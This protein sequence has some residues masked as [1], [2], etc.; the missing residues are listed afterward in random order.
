[1]VAI[2]RPGFLTARE[3]RVR[4][5]V[6][7]AGLLAG[8]DAA[9]SELLRRRATVPRRRLEPGP[10][11]APAHAGA[12]ASLGLLVLDGLMIRSLDLDGRRCPELIGPG[13]LLRPWDDDGPGAVCC[14]ATW[15]VLEPTAL[16]VL[17][18]RFAAAICRWPAIVSELLSRA[19]ERSRALAFHLAIAHIRHAQTRLRMLLWHLADRW[20]R[21]TD[22]GV[23]VPLALT[24]ELLAHLAC[25]RR[26]SAS[27]ALQLLARGGELERRRD[28][29]W[30]LT[31]S[32]P[33]SPA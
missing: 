27:T 17:D 14:A 33:A 11:E 15:S 18:D 4:V 25:M 30:L 9:S 28:G 23:H 2:E 21:V 19:V 31:G 1:M 22:R 5:F 6:E 8:V 29:T 3:D 26:P 10:W 12:G 16:A 20:G 32:P 7:D 24:H 13:D